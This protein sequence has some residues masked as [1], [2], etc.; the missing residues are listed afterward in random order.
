MEGDEVRE[1]QH[2]GD[3]AQ[4]RQEEVQRAERRRVEPVGPSVLLQIKKKTIEI[5]GRA[6]SSC[7]AACLLAR[8]RRAAT[9][10]SSMRTPATPFVVGYCLRGGWRP[11]FII[12]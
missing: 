4:R 6:L 11:W 1:R 2:Q 10:T 12:F 9:T 7:L 8:V 5:A 3:E